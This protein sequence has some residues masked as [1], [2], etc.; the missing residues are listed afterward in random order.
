MVGDE[1]SA[2]GTAPP[3]RSPHPH[4]HHPPSLHS[5]R[6]LH[7]GRPDHRGAGRARNVRGECAHSGEA[8]GAG[9]VPSLFSLVPSLTRYTPLPPRYAPFS[10]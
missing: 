6:S 2:K 5:L 8:G 1:A 4:T 10:H 3:L 9:Y 7:S